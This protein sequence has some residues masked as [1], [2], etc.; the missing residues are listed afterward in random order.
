MEQGVNNL[1]SSR[2]DDPCRKEETQMIPYIK[3]ASELRID[4]VTKPLELP[5]PLINY[6]RC[7]IEE[8]HSKRQTSITINQVNWSLTGRLKRYLVAH[9]YAVKVKRN[10]RRPTT[11]RI[12][13]NW[14]F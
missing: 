14:E 6:L 7:E 1:E 9:G 8:A 13:I 2:D 4:S 11:G 12:L 5:S 10:F 3:T